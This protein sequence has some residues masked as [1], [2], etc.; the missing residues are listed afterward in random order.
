MKPNPAVECFWIY[1][2]KA[3]I[4]DKW[5][6]LLGKDVAGQGDVYHI[7]NWPAKHTLDQLK[8]MVINKGWSG[9]T[10]GKPGVGG[11]GGGAWL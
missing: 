8:Q 2:P 11:P 7:P 5:T 1:T 6:K 3:E 9:V 10:L 4:N